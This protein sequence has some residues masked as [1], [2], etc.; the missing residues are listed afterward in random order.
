MASRKI[1]GLA[2]AT[3][4]GDAVR[5][6]EFIA[7]HPGIPQVTDLSVVAGTIGELVQLTQ[8]D[9]DANGHEIVVGLYLRIANNVGAAFDEKENWRRVGEEIAGDTLPDT[10]LYEGRIFYLEAHTVV[11]NIGW[12]VYREAA[13]AVGTPGDINYV[14]EIDAGWYI[15][16]VAI[17]STRKY[18]EVAAT[19]DATEHAEPFELTAGIWNYGGVNYIYHGSEHNIDSTQDLFNN[20][21]TDG[22]DVRTAIGWELWDT[23]VNSTANQI[24]AV[25][26]PRNADSLT[27]DQ[28]IAGHGFTAAV[29]GTYVVG[30]TFFYMDDAGDRA[31][32]VVTADF[33]AVLDPVAT[34]RD[35][36]I[37][38]LIGTEIAVTA[39]GNFVPVANNALNFIGLG[40]NNHFLTNLGHQM[41]FATEQNGNYHTD[42]LYYTTENGRMILNTERVQTEIDT[43]QDSLVGL[44]TGHIWVGSGGGNIAGISVDTLGWTRRED[45]LHEFATRAAF[46]GDTGRN[47]S[48]GGVY[49]IVDYDGADTPAAFIVTEGG[50]GWGDA[51]PRP[52]GDNTAR[53]SERTLNEEVTENFIINGGSATVEAVGGWP[54]TES[55]QKANLLEKVTVLPTTPTPDIGDSVYLT[56][57]DGTNEPGPYTYVAGTPNV[58]EAT[59]GGASVGTARP[60]PNAT[61]LATIEVE[62]GGTDTILNILNDNKNTIL[63]NLEGVDTDFTYPIPGTTNVVDFDTLDTGGGGATPGTWY[64]RANTSAGTPLDPSPTSWAD[65]EVA[66]GSPND[67]LVTIVVD[68]E[69]ADDAALTAMLGEIDAGITITGNVIITDLS[70]VEAGL[71]YVSDGTTDNAA[72]LRVYTSGTGDFDVRFVI[73]GVVSFV[74]TP[75][76]D[77]TL[78]ISSDFQTHTGTINI[79]TLASDLNVTGNATFGNGE[80]IRDYPAG[81]AAPFTIEVGDYWEFEN[82]IY[83]R[84]GNT[85]AIQTPFAF[86]NNIPSDTGVGSAWVNVTREI[87][88][89]NGPGL[90]LVT[91]DPVD[92]ITTFTLSSDTVLNRADVTVPTIQDQILKTGVVNSIVDF[93]GSTIANNS[94]FTVN[95]DADET[96]LDGSISFVDAAGIETTV[97]TEVDRLRVNSSDV[98]ASTFFNTFTQPGQDI[99]ITYRNPDATIDT[100]N[101]ALLRTTT[102]VTSIT[103]ALQ[104]SVAVAEVG[105]Y[106]GSVQNELATVYVRNGAFLPDNVLA[107]ALS[108][109]GSATEFNLTGEIVF[110]LE[111]TGI[112]TVTTGSNSNT[113]ITSDG[114]PGATTS[115]LQHQ[116]PNSMA[117]LAL[118]FNSVFVRDDGVTSDNSANIVNGVVGDFVYIQ[119]TSTWDGVAGVVFVDRVRT[120]AGPDAATEADERL[121]FTTTRRYVGTGTVTEFIFN[122]GTAVTSTIVPQV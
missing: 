19:V 39:A 75:P 34:I 67:D 83:R 18:P 11:A 28:W 79:P 27:E 57:T 69:V 38:G 122:P 101:W 104:L 72:V 70:T 110:D 96:P 22:T 7:L 52:A 86:T 91:G 12:C 2:A 117:Y 24:T 84:E 58:W 29:A 88:V 6:D 118:Q 107:Y 49:Y 120:T 55:W 13:A 82:R 103:N 48:A 4:N 44:G 76:V 30:D 73:E 46:E 5:Y 85:V 25:T 119:Y 33:T 16:G 114:V 32:Y 106:G 8:T 45:A 78:R 21:P 61:E 94:N 99:L 92:G 17:E 63:D 109:T 116:S 81:F 54:T 65:L 113:Q 3:A 108:V 115:T 87:L 41:E 23:F 105:E 53:F 56:E 121:G 71:L 112:S 93:L 77:G 37:L 47:Y 9:F 60:A 100:T 31:N 26:Y 51:D 59:G 1:E 89:A 95:Y 102:A 36:Y 40:A 68:A 90:G 111:Q 98:D 43:K 50:Q 97:W 10:N 62:V 80:L 14:S 74:G 64:Y 20:A 66:L 42:L 35:A 15:A